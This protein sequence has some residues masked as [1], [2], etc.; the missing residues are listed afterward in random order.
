ME[1]ETKYKW[2]VY[3][4]DVKSTFLNGLKEDLYVNQ[5][6]G[7]E[8]ARNEHKVYKLKKALY[9]IK[10]APK[11]WYSRIDT[12]FLK[13]RFNRSENEHTIYI[14][15]NVND[16]IIVCLY[17]DDLIYTSSSDLLVEEFREAMIIEFEM[18]SLG[19]LHYFLGIEVTQMNEGIFISQ[20]K[21]VSNLLKKWKIGNCKPMSTPMHTNEKFSVEDIAEKVDAQFYRSLEGSLLYLTTSRPDIMHAIGLISRFMQSPSKTHLGE[22]KRILRYFYGTRNL[23]NLVY[24]I[25]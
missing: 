16:M 11:T 21:Y 13:N 4:F 7:Y 20:E 3:Q 18:T 12:Y 15:S 1:F 25:K 9:G 5:P 24:F 6:Q 14:K 8:E 10:Q 19:L 2:L 17:V 23:W 22:A